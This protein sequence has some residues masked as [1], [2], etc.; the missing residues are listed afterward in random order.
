MLSHNGEIPPIFHKSLEELNDIESVH[1]EIDFITT[2]QT[3]TF[4]Q[5]IEHSKPEDARPSSDANPLTKNRR[6]SAHKRP[7]S[8][9]NIQIP[10]GSTQG[11]LSPVK[12]LDFVKDNM[13][14]R[15]VQQQ[16]YKRAHSHNAPVTD[17][18]TIQTTTMTHR[19]TQSSVPFGYSGKIFNAFHR[20]LKI[21]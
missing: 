16:E 13:L 8:L 14:L 21:D 17:S 1:E 7:L 11:P 6:E 5:R 2:K 19:R 20:V 15:K 9:S 3:I 4:E 10:K 12:H 18:V